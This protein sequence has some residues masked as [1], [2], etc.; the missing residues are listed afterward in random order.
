[1]FSVTFKVFSEAT[2]KVTFSS[3]SL[4]FVKYFA[5]FALSIIPFL[6]NT[7]EMLT[8]A[9]IKS[10]T[11]VITKAINVIAEFFLNLPRF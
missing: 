8:P 7:A 2:I 1:M 5:S 10:T 11:I 3:Y 9:K 6:P 4:S